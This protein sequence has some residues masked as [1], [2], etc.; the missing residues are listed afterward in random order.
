[1][2]RLMILLM[3]MALA[4][5][6]FAGGRRDTGGLT[7]RPGVLQIGMDIGYPPF[8]FFAEDGVTPMGFD[9]ELGKALAQRMGLRPEFINTAWEGIFAGVNTNRYDVIISAVTITPA[10]LEAHNFSN[11]YISNNLAM[12]GLRGSGVRARS[13]METAGLQ[14]AFQGD[15]TADHYMTNLRNQGLRFIE[16]RYDQIIRCF[17]EL[18]LG[19]VDV[20]V[21]DSVVAFDYIAPA[22]SPFEILWMSTEGEEFGIC[23]RKGNDALTE[24][25]NKALAELFADGTMLR[26]SN[27][28]FGMDLVS[29]VRR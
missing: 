2:K 9:V 28:F 29:S 13:P 12:V 10:R 6:V 1:M 4:G 15:T 7:I 27:Q 11:P 8:E 20:I 25:I 19:R 5:G 16:R 17:E 24:A 3:I 22:N 14:V 18:R 26:L 23:M 21:T